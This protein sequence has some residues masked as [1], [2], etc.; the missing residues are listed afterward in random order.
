MSEIESGSRSDD[1]SAALAHLEQALV[2][3]DQMKAPRE[4]GALVDH[5]IHR[6]RAALIP[7]ANWDQS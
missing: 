1:G 2:L 6:L 7:T 3:L 5:A 4:I